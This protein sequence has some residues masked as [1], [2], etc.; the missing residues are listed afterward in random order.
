ML[1]KLSSMRL[2]IS[3]MLIIAFACVLGTLIPQQEVAAVLEQHLSSEAY[4]ML[5]MLELDQVYTARWF[6]GLIGLLGLNILLCTLKNYKESRYLI[7]EKTPPIPDRR[8]YHAVRS[9]KL[10]ELIEKLNAYFNQ[11]FDA[12]QTAMTYYRRSEQPRHLSTILLHLSILLI[13][14]GMSLRSFGLE[15]FAILFPGQE[16]D[17]LSSGTHEAGFTMRCE[18]FTVETYENGMPKEFRS[19]LSFWDQ[20]KLL[21]RDEL[22]VNHPITFR[23]LR[24]YQSGYQGEATARLR[25]SAPGLQKELSLRSGQTKSINQNLQL[26]AIKI[27]PNLMEMGPAVQL[28]IITDKGPER[29]ILFQEIELIRQARPNILQMAP[30][31]DPDMLAPYHFELQE[32]TPVY[33]TGITVSRDPGMP[34]TAAGAIGL[35]AGIMLTLLMPRRETW[36]EINFGSIAVASERNWLPASPPA[37][38]L[39]IVNEFIVEGL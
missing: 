6:L 28:E 10:N 23:G 18:D 19:V 29:L 12:N 26:H 21:L 14:L 13:I 31:F 32:L 20:E 33:S 24:F 36:I 17:Q 35:L 5:T 4:Q 7:R 25:I 1:S 16:T 3:L 30:S 22:L 34:V 8:S 9:D 27:A 2:A 38:L 11:D 39:A 15:D 37:R